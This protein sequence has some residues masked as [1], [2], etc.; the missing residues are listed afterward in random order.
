MHVNDKLCLCV[1]PHVTHHDFI[2]TSSSLWIKIDKLILC[3]HQVSIVKLHY[4][5]PMI[6]DHAIDHGR[7]RNVKR[8][9]WSNFHINNPET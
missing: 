3:V 1:N 8:T 4:I 9:K 5:N 2:L 6:T 7:P